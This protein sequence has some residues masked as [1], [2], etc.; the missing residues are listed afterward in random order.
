MVRTV[1]VIDRDE[2]QITMAADTYSQRW[3]LYHRCTLNVAVTQSAAIGDCNAVTGQENG[4][5]ADIVRG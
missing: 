2:E 4:R 3:K 5:N 1:S